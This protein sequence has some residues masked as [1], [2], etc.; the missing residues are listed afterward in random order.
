MGGSGEM[1]IQKMCLITGVVN[2][3]VTVQNKYRTYLHWHCYQFNNAKIGDAGDIY[4]SYGK[5]KIRLKSDIP[6]YLNAVYFKADPS[7]GENST[8]E[9]K[10]RFQY[11]I[12]QSNSY[13]T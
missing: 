9:G 3:K 13:Y 11:S 7:Q 12:S 5:M 1:H 4:K 10:G 6:I 2:Q 8:T